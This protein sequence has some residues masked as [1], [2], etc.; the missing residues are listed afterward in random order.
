MR[1]GN[2]SSDTH[3]KRILHREEYNIIS[4]PTPRAILL[5]AF[6]PASP[7]PRT[8]LAAYTLICA[9]PASALYCLPGI[10]NKSPDQHHI[11][12]RHQKH[13]FNYINYSILGYL[14]Q[15]NCRIQP[16][17][18]FRNLIRA[19]AWESD[20]RFFTSIFNVHIAPLFQT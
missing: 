7:P 3:F 13:L 11:L 19:A 10:S 14:A 20:K 16:H 12:S 2:C 17:H 5:R 15:V 18:H 8:L 1:N 6:T 9:S 4:P